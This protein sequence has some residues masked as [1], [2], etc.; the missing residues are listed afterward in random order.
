MKGLRLNSRQIGTS[1][2]L[3]TQEILNNIQV[4]IPRLEI[5]KR[6]V[7]I[8]KPLDEKIKVNEQINHNLAQMAQAIFKSWF[9]NFEPFGGEMPSNWLV[10]DFSTFLTPRIEK[11]ND[12]D[13]PLF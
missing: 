9:V 11:S 5:Q 12:P 13:I 8:I 1:Q 3:L 6:I 4:Q 2:P 10:V 7:N